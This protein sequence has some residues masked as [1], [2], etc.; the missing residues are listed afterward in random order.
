MNQYEN[1]LAGGAVEDFDATLAQFQQALR[2]A[3]IDEIVAAKQ[4]QL[5]AFLA[6]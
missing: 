1:A 4:E 3:G 5:D 2:D 6:G